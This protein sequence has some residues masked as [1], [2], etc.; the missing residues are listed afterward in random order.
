MTEIADPKVAAAFA[1]FPKVPRVGLLRLCALILDTA[2]GMVEAQPLQ[3][4]LKWGK[5]AYL[6]PRGS[7]LRLGCPTSGGFALYLHCQSR[8]IPDYLDQFEDLDRIERT[9]AILFRAV[10][11]ID[12][13][14]HG[15]LIRRALT[16]HIRR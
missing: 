15:W 9:R 1:A 6:A 4:T 10:G 7:I 8:L 3:E 2:R 14:R 13:M 16:Y 11:E 12:P 5:P